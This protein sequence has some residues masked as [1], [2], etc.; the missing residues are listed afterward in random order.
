M[1]IVGRLRQTPMQL[2]RRFTETPYKKPRRASPEESP[3]L[4]YRSAAITCG[5]GLLISTCSLTLWILNPDEIDARVRKFFPIGK[6]FQII[7]KV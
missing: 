4:S 7:A 3:S 5:P 1:P 6:P 2:A